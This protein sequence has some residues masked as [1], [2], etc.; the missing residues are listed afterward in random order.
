VAER[1]VG[2]GLLSRLGIG[3]G[4]TLVQVPP[5]P[6]C[7][8]VR[9]ALE[10]GGVR[11]TV[12]NLE[13]WDRRPVAELTGGAYYVVPVLV[14]A[15]GRTPP[16][17]VYESRDDGTD[18]AR[19][20]DAKYD[21]GLFPAHL[22]GLQDLVV[23]YVEGQC[24]DVAFRLDDAFL[25]PSIEDVGGRTMALRH[26]E[27]KFGKGCVDQWREQAPDLLA[28]LEDV[29]RPLDRMLARDPF[30]LGDRPTFA[31]YAL[32]GVLGNLTYTGDCQIPARLTNILR[33]HAQVP[34]VTLGQLAARQPAPA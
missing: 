29:L 26:K 22:E 27:R 16:V 2:Q 17:C 6:F 28:K 18:I 7:I 1:V 5:S 11:H 10:A 30:L 31:D 32:Y 9:T 21:L 25:L 34:G 4:L 3:G 24:E 15:D 12:H 33:W 23:Q 20:V 13:L 19:Y 8:S 14:D